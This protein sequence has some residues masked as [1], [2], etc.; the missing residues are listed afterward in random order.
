MTVLEVPGS[1]RRSG[2]VSGPSDGS[3][4]RESVNPVS[5]ASGTATPDLNSACGLAEHQDVSGR[6]GVVIAHPDA[7]GRVR[8]RCRVER[9]L[10]LTPEFMLASPSPTLEP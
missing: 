1:T 5:M 9:R 6:P 4:L 8:E 10:Q 7:N 3:V 2:T